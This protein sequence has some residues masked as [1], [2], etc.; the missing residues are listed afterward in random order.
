MSF[1]NFEFHFEEDESNIESAGSLEVFDIRLQ[2]GNRP[3]VK[4]LYH[5]FKLKN[6]TMSPDMQILYKD[7]DLYSVLHA[8]STISKGAKIKELVYEAEALTDNAQTIDLLPNTR[9]KE[10]LK[11]G[12]NTQITLSA[13][14]NI[15]AEETPQNVNLGNFGQVD[16]GGG[17]TLKTSA[18]GGIS[19]SFSF[20]FR[21]PVVQSMGVSS[22][23]CTWVLQPESNK[24]L[25][26]DQLLMQIL[27]VPKGTKT[28]KYR[29]VAE[30]RA[31]KGF[32]WK[33]KEQK[34]EPLE[35]EIEL[36]P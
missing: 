8:I 36:Q 15:S 9:F 19:G 16:L 23:K 30:I 11:G 33:Q 10:W 26:G 3:I 29:I 5:L 32:F 34:T 21:F 25:N 20:S 31:S 28:I 12:I 4:N 7:K 2:V 24:P 22:N 14:G 27:A 35:I 1:Q 17:L 6:E 13:N 18:E